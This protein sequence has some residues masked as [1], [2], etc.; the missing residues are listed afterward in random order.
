MQALLTSA[1][2]KEWLRF[3]SSAF[4]WIGLP[5]I[6]A[7]VFLP[8]ATTP[9]MVAMSCILV[10]M[11]VLGG[12]GYWSF[13]R[14]QDGR[15]VRA[16]I[17][18]LKYVHWFFLELTNKTAFLDEQ[19]ARVAREHEK[20][21]CRKS[22][23]ALLREAEDFDEWLPMVQHTWF[24]DVTDTLSAMGSKR[25]ALRYLDVDTLKELAVTLW[26]TKQ[27]LPRETTTVLIAKA[28]ALY[29]L[30]KNT[31]NPEHLREASRAY[32]DAIVE[33][34]STLDHLVTFRDTQ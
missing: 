14:L 18:V 24:H 7:F 34:L 20:R 22:L 12:T 6:L 8:D 19:A 29:A 33:M 13:R 27:L 17:L 31:R 32:F 5:A 9:R 26:C 28:Q 1:P 15:G 23:L 10:Y 30:G 25:D 3:G 4:V 16:E 2:K 21:A 11:S